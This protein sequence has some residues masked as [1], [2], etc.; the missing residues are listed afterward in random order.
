M[1]SLEAKLTMVMAIKQAQVEN[2]G[3]FAAIFSEAYKP[4]LLFQ[5][6]R[7]DLV[8]RTLQCLASCSPADLK[9]PLKVEF[10]GEEAVDDGGVLKHRNL[11]NFCV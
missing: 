10:D 9:R 7:T 5:V 3:P 11:I 6:S 8:P 1:L 4:V 2:L